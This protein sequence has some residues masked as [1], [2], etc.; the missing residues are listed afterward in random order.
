MKT[1]VA[2]PVLTGL[3]FIRRGLARATGLAAGP[4]IHPASR[5]L[6]L[7]L[8]LL[9]TNARGEWQRDNVSLTWKSGD[10]IVWRF[11][12]DPASGKPFFHPLGPVGGPVVT[13][14]QPADHPWHYGLWF[15]WKYIQPQA[16]AGTNANHTNYWEEDRT[17]G[18]AAGKTS[19]SAPV[20]ETRPDGGATI[21][22]DVT[23]TSPKGHVD[24]IESREIKVSAP[25]A[26]GGF[27]LDWRARFIVGTVAV[28]LD[29][30]PMPG[31]PGGAVNGGYAGMSLR[32][33]GRPLAIAYLSTAGPVMDFPGSRARPAAPATAFNFSQ[34]GKVTGG[35]AFLSSPKNAGENAPWYL[36]ND[37]RGDFF[38][39]DQTLL[40]PKPLPLAAG[41]QLELR[42]RF[43]LS[44][45]EWT[46]ESLRAAQAAWQKPDAAAVK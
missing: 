32:M 46:P 11:N 28:V 4:L 9:A 35:I 14:R 22:L 23:Y 37:V 24:M 15:S 20:I 41:E 27:T 36:I 18:N 25:D 19:W 31:E 43:V 33:A 1:P 12:F 5:L 10:T 2:M 44:R 45:A 29:R 21:H 6:L 34:D 30:T 13:N 8:G 17:T 42:Y 40:A 16:D 26:S 3:Q 38:F 39:A 7:A